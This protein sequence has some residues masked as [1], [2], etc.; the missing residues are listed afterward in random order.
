MRNHMTDRY[1]II[2][3]LKARDLVKTN[4]QTGYFP[5]MLCRPDEI[6]RW[7]SIHNETETMRFGI[8]KRF[9]TKRFYYAL[10][11]WNL[12][13]AS[14]MRKD[15]SV[16][17]PQY[18]WKPANASFQQLTCNEDEISEFRHGMYQEMQ[19]VADAHIFS[20]S[21]GLFLS[22]KGINQPMD[23]VWP[24]PS[25][26]SPEFTVILDCFTEN[27]EQRQIFS[28]ESYDRTFVSYDWEDIKDYFVDV[29]LPLLE[30]C[31]GQNINF[32]TEK[33]EELFAACHHLDLEKI[34]EAVQHGAN[35]FALNQEGESAIY[36]CA[37]DDGTVDYREI[38]ERREA[39]IDFLLSQGVD[40]NLFGYGSGCTPLEFCWY[41]DDV[42]LLEYLLACGAEPN[43]NSEIEDIVLDSAM[44]PWFVQSAILSGTYDELNVDGEAPELLK[45]EQLLLAHG[46]KLYLDGFDTSTG[47][48]LKHPELG[49]W[50]RNPWAVPAAEGDRA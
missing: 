3:C 7:G 27:M 11:V 20:V 48:W 35:L 46:A 16:G 40:V 50:G 41:N 39:C 17:L 10:Q 23:D 38:A 25:C 36:A 33:D 44:N 4:Q 8:S 42:V 14:L 26:T 31:N 28:Q 5:V 9:M 34:K 13:L 24:H 18:R 22:E 47:I 45:M 19:R 49:A 30:L 1:S 43:I 2:D 6:E 37:D 12:A 29:S 15:D 21:E 32:H